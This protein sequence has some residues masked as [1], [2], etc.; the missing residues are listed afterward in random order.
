MEYGWDDRPA[1]P[2]VLVVAG[3]SPVRGGIATFAEALAHDPD[4][5]RVADV[6]LLNTTRRA[7]RRAGN[8]SVE[9]VRNV[10]VDAVRV[11]TRGRGVDVVHVHSAPGRIFPLLRT[12]VLCAAG[13]AAGAAVV[14]HVHSSKLNGGNPEGFRPGR[15]FAAAARLLGACD[16]LPTVSDTGTHVLGDLVP[17]T[18]TMTVPNAV[19]VDDFSTSDVTASPVRLLFVGTVCERKGLS[20]LLEACQRLREQDLPPWRLVVVGGAA[21]V[22]EAEAAGLRAEYERAGFDDVF[23]G[24]REPVE[25][26]EELARAGVLVLPSLWEGQPMAVLEAM[27]SAVPVVATRI[28]AVPQTVRDGV[29]GL[30]VEA[31]DAR[32][33]AGALAQLI[34]EPQTRRE[35]GQHAQER[36]RE[37][38]AMAALAQR[39]D[40]VYAEALRLRADRRRPRRARPR[41]TVGI[42]GG[43]A[44]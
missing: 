23:V 44:G 42:A 20:V 16:V 1:R 25:V 24:P 17:G 7:V 35:M 37:H 43:S 8:L 27:A 3:A 2:R 10:V 33:L 21:E 38:F 12:V 14:C 28:G 34:A 19:P 41:R 40:T 6:R 22:G 4:V 29:D 5:A 36:A 31:G 39:L 32:A 13:R 9:N 15:A 30:L 18:L 11:W 26:R